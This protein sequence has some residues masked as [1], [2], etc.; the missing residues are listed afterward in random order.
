MTRL[1]HRAEANLKICVKKNIKENDGSVTMVVAQDMPIYTDRVRV[2]G[3]QDC[4][5]SPFS[6]SPHPSQRPIFCTLPAFHVCSYFRYIPFH[7]TLLQ[8]RRLS[9]QF[10]SLLLSQQ[11]EIFER[12]SVL[13]FYSFLHFAK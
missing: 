6:T 8:G 3:K 11:H 4:S 7:V 1:L 10:L 9:I 5:T 13:E 2:R 12:F